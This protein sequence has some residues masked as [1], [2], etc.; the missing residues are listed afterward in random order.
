VN[1]EVGR[2]D[3]TPRPLSATYKDWHDTYGIT[4]QPAATL[5][6][7]LPGQGVQVTGQLLDSA[8]IQVDAGSHTPAGSYTYQATG[9]AGSAAGNYTLVRDATSWLDSASGMTLSVG[10]TNTAK[11]QVDKAKLT[12]RYTGLTDMVYGTNPTRPVVT[13][14]V[15]GDTPDWL[16]WLTTTSSPTSADV[17]KSFDLGWKNYVPAG[18]YDFSIRLSDALAKNYEVPAKLPG[19]TVSRRA[20]GGTAAGT[21]F[22]Y[23]DLN[24]LNTWTALTGTLS[25][26]VPGDD[27]T[28]K[29]VYVDSKGNPVQ[30]NL[31]SDAGTYQARLTDLGGASAANYVLDPARIKTADVVIKPMPLNLYLPATRTSTYGTS[32]V[33]AI[34]DTY[35]KDAVTYLI[36]GAG[37]P[38]KALTEQEQTAKN[39]FK[40]N[41]VLD[42][43]VDAGEYTYTITLGG[44]KAGNYVLT[45]GTTGTWVIKPKTLT[46]TVSPGSGQYGYYKDCDGF[47]CTSL[48]PGV[49]IGKPVYNGVIPGD[50]VGGNVAI[51]D[52]KG[53]PMT[54]D[55]NTPVGNYFEVV[56][57]LTGAQAK[58]YT[59]ATGG[60]LP[61]TLTIN[62]LYLRYSTASSVS[63]EGQGQIGDAGKTTLQTIGGVPLPNGDAMPDAVVVIYAPYPAD[64]YA[65][66][67]TPLGEGRYYYEAI[68]L[69]GQYAGNYRLLPVQNHGRYNIPVTL[70]D[71]GVLDVYKDSRF[72]LAF[73]PVKNLPPLTVA[74]PPDTPIFSQTEQTGGAQFADQPGGSGFKRTTGEENKPTPDYDRPVTGNGSVFETHAGPSGAVA[75]AGGAAETDLVSGTV[76]VNAQASG[77][78]T[79]LAS[80]GVS[81]VTVSATAD[82]HVDITINSGPVEGSAG[83]QAEVGVDMKIGRT[84]IKIDA[85]ATVGAYASG[86]VHGG[87]GGGLDG[88]VNLTSGT[89]AY[90][91]TSYNYGVTNGVLTMTTGAHTGVGFSTGVSGGFSGEAGA[92]QG[93]ATLYSP[94]SIGGNFTVGAGYSNGVIEVSLDLGAQLGIGGLELKLNFGV[95][96]GKV[97]AVFSDLAHGGGPTI[98]E[99][100]R[101]ADSHAL[102]LKNDPAARFAYL[103]GNTD[104]NHDGDG[105]HDNAVFLQQYTDML[106]A[107]TKMV[108]DEQNWQKTFINLLQADPAKAVEFS[109]EKPDFRGQ[110]FDVQRQAAI[111]GVRMRVDDGQLVYANIPR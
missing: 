18:T 10:P 45:G 66:L 98:Y 4:P 3:I 26:M 43:L 76:N 107:T 89:F 56:S 101:E 44:A 92:V 53:A 29:Q 1:G 70:N 105:S 31:Y 109:R 90:A 47:S 81:G 106:K 2:I 42:Q 35:P 25:G 24:G 51:L 71:L 49:D 13:G 69:T 82:G 32:P 54:V 36:S 103:S 40:R 87:L 73:V 14:F 63:I 15:P 88:N 30:P 34:A 48:V 11:V 57:G 72:G 100:Q 84:G 46:W 65:R 16:A 9:L 77:V 39:N 50:D 74:Q 58:N 22:V 55:A 111:L 27:L 96:V 5:N 38:G 78:A 108:T 7:V 23:T 93:G 33:F 20:L 60:N 28:V 79:A 80:F 97:G 95:D 64:G 110:Y 19:L 21:S 68:G 75:A 52:L 59:L 91:T 102:S 37:L 41:L 8:G 83:A 17:G 85:D 67:G 94:G 61:G 12:V 99:R 6:G 86:G 104:W 62:P